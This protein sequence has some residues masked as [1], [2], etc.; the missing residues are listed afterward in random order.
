MSLNSSCDPCS[1]CMPQQQHV[2]TGCCYCVEDGMSQ[3]HH[4]E[5]HMAWPGIEMAGGSG[6]LLQVT[7]LPLVTAAVQVQVGLCPNRVI[8]YHA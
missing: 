3:E 8:S 1:G 5:T 4:L 2:Q 6:L 7:H